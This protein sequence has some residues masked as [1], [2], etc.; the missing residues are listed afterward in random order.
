MKARGSGKGRVG[1]TMTMLCQFLVA[2]SLLS[3]VKV[4]VG[5][6]GLVR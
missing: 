1:M 2:M 4:D 6:V 3:V 5:A